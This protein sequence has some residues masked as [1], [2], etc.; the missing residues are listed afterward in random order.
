MA[1]FIIG[2]IHACIEEFEEL[3]KLINPIKNKIILCGDLVDRGVDSLGVVRKARELNIQSVMGNHDL[4][5]LNEIPHY[6][7][8]N[9]SDDDISYLRS[10]PNYI[11]LEK[12]IILHAGLMPGISLEN[13]SQEDLLKLRYLDKDHNRYSITKIRKMLPKITNSEYLSP[14]EKN[15][16]IDEQLKIK[17]NELQIK[18]W[19]FF[20]SGEKEV[21]CGH[22]V[23]SLEK[24]MVL[25]SCYGIDTGCV[26][27]GFLT[28]ICLETKELIQVKSNYS[29]N[30]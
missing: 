6:N 7:R 19:S 25:N 24:P 18:P 22:N 13:Q 17:I 30:F 27:G 26:F 2:D 23:F 8:Y 20:Y 3:L 12:S 11:E 15:K 16:I 1:T 9:L 5:I 4:K 21:F 29:T 28:A 14:A 10:F